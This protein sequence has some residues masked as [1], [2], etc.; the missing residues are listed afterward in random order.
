MAT[1]IG[2]LKK[3]ALK[4]PKQGVVAALTGMKDRPSREILLKFPPFP[5]YIIAGA[6]DPRVPLDES[7]RLSQISEFVHL[8]VIK[9]CGHMSF[10]EAPNE[11]IQLLKRSMH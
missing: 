5:V 6:Q 3:E 8:F 10:L 11:A 4:T 7:E 2:E 1:E 9:N